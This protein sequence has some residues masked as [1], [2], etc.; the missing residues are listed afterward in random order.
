[1]FG[2]LVDGQ[3][4]MESGNTLWS[5]R[6]SDPGDENAYIVEAQISDNIVSWHSV[7]STSN[8]LNEPNYTYSYIAIG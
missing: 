7:S 4:R 6:T 3:G 5:N 8:Q 1:M 2:T